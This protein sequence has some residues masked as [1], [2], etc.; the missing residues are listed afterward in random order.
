MQGPG[1]E[2]S[3]DRWPCWHRSRLHKIKSTA[4][5][6]A[7]SRNLRCLHYSRVQI[8][9]IIAAQRCP[10]LLR[11]SFALTNPML[12]FCAFILGHR[13][14]FENNFLRRTRS[15]R[16]QKN[17]KSNIRRDKSF[18]FWRCTPPFIK[19][20]FFKYCRRR[21]TTH[22]QKKTKWAIN[23]IYLQSG[24]LE[25]QLNPDLL[26]EH[27]R[28]RYI[29]ILG[30]WRVDTDAA[31]ETHNTHRERAR[32]FFNASAACSWPFSQS[33]VEQQSTRTNTAYYVPI[34]FSEHWTDAVKWQSYVP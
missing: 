17:L 27:L 15:N 16:R 21:Q 14:Y 24:N 32:S 19:V 10:F 34:H 33:C 20:R 18:Y 23:A 8:E 5:S 7:N 3:L 6:A 12:A 4:I 11:A 30:S 1:D 13:I 29:M 26:A 22:F 9:V 28:A 31:R 2:R 25:F